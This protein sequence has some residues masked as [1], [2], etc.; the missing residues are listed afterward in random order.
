[1]DVTYIYK[2]ELPYVV[3]CLNGEKHALHSGDIVRPAVISRNG[4]R[5]YKHA[6]YLFEVTEKLKKCLDRVYDESE[7]EYWR[8]LYHKTAI[9]AMQGI[10]SNKA[11]SDILVKEG[12]DFQTLPGMVADVAIKYTD[13]LIKELQRKEEEK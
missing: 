8:T 3:T 5:I 11:L 10:A 1:M 9:A 13:S 4:N 2:E 6:E 12:A 7:V